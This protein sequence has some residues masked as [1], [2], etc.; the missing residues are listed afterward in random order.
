MISGPLCPNITCPTLV[1]RGA[2]TDLLASDTAQQMLET[3]PNSQ[4]VEIPQAGHMVFEDNPADF[5]AAVKEF[6]G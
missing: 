3:I 2:E 5:I 1:V 4:L 6:L